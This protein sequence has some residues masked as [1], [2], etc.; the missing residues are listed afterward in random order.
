MRKIRFISWRV[1]FYYIAIFIIFNESFLSSLSYIYVLKF[2]RLTNLA[3][4]VFALMLFVIAQYTYRTSECKKYD[5]ATKILIGGMIVF[6]F[7]GIFLYPTYSTQTSRFVIV[8]LFF[9]MGYRDDRWIDVFLKMS[10]V[11]G[12]IYIVTT[13]WFSIDKTIYYNYFAF[14]MYPNYLNYDYVNSSGMAGITD[15]Y[16]TNGM[17]LANIAILIF[18]ALLS[19][20][21]KISIT[22][23]MLFAA[24]VMALVLCGKRAHFA[25]V[26]VAC[27]LTYLS[28]DYKKKGKISK[29]IVV[30]FLLFVIYNLLATYSPEFQ[31][32]IARFDNMTESR[33]TLI[34]YQLW[35]SGIAGFYRNPILGVG[36]PGGRELTLNVMAGNQ[37]VHNE[38]IQ[39]LCETGIVGTIFFLGFII[40]ACFIAVKLLFMCSDN[41]LTYSRRTR[42]CVI[43]S[44]AYQVFFVIYCITASPLHQAYTSNC[45]YFAAFLGIY[46]YNNRKRYFTK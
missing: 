11:F 34:R 24:S 41:S 46:I 19:R 17:M 21:N 4:D 44:F 9:L 39:I 16:S 18:A 35:A 43:F 12:L 8:I 3:M 42:C 30:I 38:L 36:W 40:L 15:H 27:F 22:Y 20:K 37:D 7:A 6:Y 2:N 10:I 25:F 31:S 23:L 45:Y 5:T 14:K 32:L 29:T 33:T 26:I 13:I 1:L 28:I